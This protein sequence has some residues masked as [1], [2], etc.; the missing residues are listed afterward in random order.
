[1]SEA[2]HRDFES[3]S[4][5]LDELVLRAAAI[6]LVQ[7]A[8]QAVAERTRAATEGNGGERQPGGER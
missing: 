7:Q 2:T 5:A 3:L 4:R 6:Q 8:E 1:M